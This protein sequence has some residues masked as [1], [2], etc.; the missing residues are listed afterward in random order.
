MSSDS[1]RAYRL[2]DFDRTLFDTAS[3]FDWLWRTLANAHGVDGSV[4]MSRAKKF[5]VHSG[6]WYDYKFFDHIA[7]I[8]ELQSIPR[9]RLIEKLHAATRPSFLFKD[10]AGVIDSCDEIITFG[11]RDY[12]ELK[13]GL[14]P[15]VSSLPVTII[16]ESKAQ[17]IVSHFKPPVML[18][19]DKHLEDELPEWVFFVLID[20]QQSEPI[21]THRPNFITINALRELTKL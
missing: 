5:Y 6:D 1:V 3:F 10:A 16:Q 9:E 4:E 17:Y 11:N 20:R 2:V 8:P 15:E 18:I 21:V 12:Q 7:T 13:L 14:C 19:D